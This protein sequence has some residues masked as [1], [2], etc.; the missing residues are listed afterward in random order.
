MFRASKVRRRESREESIGY[1]PNSR[2]NIVIKV[3]LDESTNNAWFPNPGILKKKR[4]SMT[5]NSRDP[6]Y[7]CF[8]WTNSQIF[9]VTF[10]F[11]L[12]VARGAGEIV[13]Q[14]RKHRDYYFFNVRIM[15][16]SPCSSSQD[17]LLLYF[18]GAFIILLEGVQH[19]KHNHLLV[20]K[21]KTH[22]QTHGVW[23]PAKAWARE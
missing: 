16:S 2:T 8:T 20:K 23:N 9:S 4:K 15:K 14:K 21:K 13:Q 10:F 22:F 5:V 17:F 19:F 11:F 3:V 12:L 18:W 6:R 7:L 1:L